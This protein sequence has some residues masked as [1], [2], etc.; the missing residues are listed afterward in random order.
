[1]KKILKEALDIILGIFIVAILVI[2]T[3]YFICKN[4]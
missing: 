3:L 4:Y 1:M 2:V